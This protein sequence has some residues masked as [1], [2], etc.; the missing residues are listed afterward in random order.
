M[1]ENK[2]VSVKVYTYGINYNLYGKTTAMDADVYTIE[3]YPEQVI[4]LAKAVALTPNFKSYDRV[5]MRWQFQGSRYMYHFD[6]IDGCVHVSISEN[7]PH[8]WPN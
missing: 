3:C 5:E 8:Q 7:T 6:K 4:T 1:E 2:K